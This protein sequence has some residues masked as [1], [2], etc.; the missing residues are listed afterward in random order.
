MKYKP[1][2]KKCLERYKRRG[3]Q[4]FETCNRP[5]RPEVGRLSIVISPFLI[6]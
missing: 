2:G 4:F 6:N 5:I 1:T 3:I